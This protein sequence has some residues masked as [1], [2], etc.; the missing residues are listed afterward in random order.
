M[1]TKDIAVI[2]IRNEMGRYFIHQ[3][4]YHKQVFPGM[5]GVGAGGHIKTHETPVEA[6]KRELTEETGLEIEP[7]FLFSFPFNHSGQSYRVHVFE[8]RTDEIIEPS[9]D[10]WQWSGWL[11]EDEIKGLIDQGVLMPDTTVFYLRYLYQKKK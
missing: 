5:Y 2:I 1:D 3:R 11:N 7:E 6:A 9:K 8:V 10:E 4:S